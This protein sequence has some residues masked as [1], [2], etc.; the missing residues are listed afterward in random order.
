MAPPL[1]QLKDIALTFGGTPLLT[2]AELTVAA[3]ERVC[4]VGRNGSG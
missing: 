1:V 3:G 4:L 2:E